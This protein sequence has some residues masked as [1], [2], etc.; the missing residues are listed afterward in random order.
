MSTPRLKILQIGAGAMGTRRM[1]DLHR[2]PDVSLGLFDERPDRRATAAASFGVKTFASLAEALAWEPGAMII[3]TP[4]GAK[5]PHIDLCFDRGLPHFSEAD[6]WTYGATRRNAQ[7]PGLVATASC[8]L[9]FL[10]VVK[11]LEGL[12]REHL[13]TLL[14]YHHILGTFMPSWHPEEGME[15]YGRHR[16]TAPAREMVCFELHFL[17]GIFGPALEA[18]GH[19]E[20]YGEL[21]GATED[22]WSL[23]FRLEHGGTGQ[24]TSTM[25]SPD[26]FRRGCCLGSKNS[27]TWDLYTGEVTVSGGARS[28]RFGAIESVL[29]P[30]YAEEINT[31]V[32]AVL[33][34]KQWSQS[35]ALCQQATAMLAAAEKSAATGRWAAVDPGAEPERDP[36]VA[37]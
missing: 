33:G 7:A 37:H 20:K 8:S 26:N 13:G 1:R 25:A 2:R 32:D 12:V 10:P 21:E 3:S 23:L 19:F 24:L 14:S 17:N 9:R 35:Y 36:P 30:G 6:I 29:D 4:P 18:A 15:Y 28:Y 22:T 11:G 16:D 31:F 5:G 27:L 34:R